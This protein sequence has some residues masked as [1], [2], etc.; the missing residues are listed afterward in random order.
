M[1]ARRCR[2]W[3]AAAALVLLATASGGQTGERELSPQQLRALGY[4][5]FAGGDIPTALN[6]A[7]ALLHRDPKDTSAL[8][9]RAQARQARH[10]EAGARADA[11]L[12]YRYARSGS[13]RFSAA[14]FMANANALSDNKFGAQLWLRKADS[15]APDAAAKD[16]ARDGYRAIRARNPWLL[17]FDINLRPSSNVNNGSSETSFLYQGLPWVNPEIPISGA[18][19]ALSGLVAR[20]TLDATYRFAPSE[21]TRTEFQFHVDQSQVRLSQEARAAAPLARA[22]DY[23]SA[24]LEAGL[25]RL[26]RPKDSKLT[27]RLAGFTSRD[28]YGGAAL[29]NNNR[30]ELGAVATLNRDLQ[31][32]LALSY[33]RQDRLDSTI[34]SADVTSA[35]VG[36]MHVVASGDV[37]QLSLNQRD[38]ATQSAGLR[39]T[40]RALRLSWTK[41][42]PVKGVGLSVSGSYERR[43]YPTSP[44]DP[45]HGRHDNRLALNM[46]MDLTKLDYMGFSPSVTLSASQNRS[47]VGLYSS[48][49]FGINL[50]FKSN[51]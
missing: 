35:S 22:D 50:G 41:A 42:K 8:M 36:L 18:D 29:A 27:Y 17:S 10:D 13:T 43:D 26:Y 21:T 15:A 23:A 39:N 19:A 2:D 31:A 33:E 14:M 20:A 6:I 44:F 4:Q 12:A 1:M 37:V 34:R 38:T 28:W 46:A 3:L 40:A 48:K 25:V 7:E 11:R 9:L 45:L 32:N 49:E 16:L 30:L 5:V 47:T 24:T 51:F